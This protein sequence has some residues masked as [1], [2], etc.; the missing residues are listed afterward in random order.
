MIKQD[1]LYGWDLKGESLVFEVFEMLPITF[2]TNHT[3]QVLKCM[4]TLLVFQCTTP[5]H[6]TH[7]R[8][9]VNRELK[10]VL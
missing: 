8:C 1:W 10:V 4:D 6:L 3:Q 2:K 9:I 5:L 7:G